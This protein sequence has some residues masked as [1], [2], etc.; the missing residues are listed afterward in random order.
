MRISVGKSRKDMDWRVKEL[1]WD[2]LM[3]Q[4]ET[5]VRTKETIN[6]YKG[7]SKG[8]KA[9]IKDVGGFVGGVISGGRRKNG[10]VTSRSLVTLDADTA[11][12]RLW[13]N[14][15]FSYDWTMA[16]YTTHSHQPAKPRLRLLFELDR[17]VSAEEYVPI[18]R[19]LAEMIGI[20]QFDPTTYEPT[21]L[22]YWP[23]VCADG[24][25]LFE[26][27]EG[28]P[29]CA[30]DILAE[31]ED[32]RDT[33]QWPM[34]AE[35]NRI[36]ERIAKNQGEP[37]E[38]AG[39]VGAFCRT[40]NAQEA[41]DTFLSDVYVPA[42]GDRYT[43]VPGSTFAGVV[44]YNDG[45]FSYSHHATDPAGGYLCN[46]FDLVRLHK[47]KDLD[48][49]AE[50]GTPVNKL[51]SYQK[52]LELASEDVEVKKLILA[53]KKKEL[54]EDFKPVD[55]DWAAL[56]TFTK[57]GEVEPTRKNIITILRYDDAY[58]DCFAYNE[59]S[60][61]DVIRKPLDWKTDI[62][63]TNGTAITDTDVRLLRNRLEASYGISGKDMIDDALAEV[64]HGNRFH[65]VRSYLQGLHW[66][67]VRRM[68]EL[69]IDYMGAEDCAYSRIVT[70]RWLISAVARIMRPGCKADA[71]LVL[72][73]AQG[74]GK[75]Y[76]TRR[77][78]KH[79]SSDT[80]MTVTGKDAYD[81]LHGSWIIEVSELAATRKADV[82]SVKS[83][84]SKQ[85]DTYRAAYAK[86]A[87]NFP[88][89]CVFLGTTNEQE[90]LIDTTGN[91]RFWPLDLTGAPANSVFDL[92][93]EYVDLV[94][95]EAYKAYLD[96]EPWWLT[97][98]ETK[99]LLTAQESHLDLDPVIGQ[100]AEYL[101][102]DLPENWKDLT[103]EQ[104]RDF[105]QGY[106]MPTEVPL[107]FKRQRICIPELV[108]EMSKT[109]PDDLKVPRKD[110]Y[111]FRDALN[112]V[113][114][115]RRNPKRQKPNGWGDQVCWDRKV[116]G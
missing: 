34:A 14:L 45:A 96:G 112:Q 109:P 72:V 32:W 5:P 21:R 113:P 88:R 25:Y 38:K 30:D 111:R 26:H 11:M 23:S 71:M 41:M 82:E 16:M 106:A 100:I 91:R 89:Q 116:D 48:A 90:F 35:E 68:S 99:F 53:E 15:S 86:R 70:K 7:M 50:P 56:L 115:W 75:S 98:Q 29:V 27:Q 39:L 64:T 69:F 93:D 108:Y 20:E 97:P 83:F 37:T 8:K 6:E 81:Q 59:F 42:S 51:P 40:Y 12:P 62:D 55:T 110:M 17:E 61:R 2:E 24:E 31:Y 10:A 47:F 13:D 18:A 77:L 3:E 95:A 43:Y 87:E 114:G 49:E 66:D 36:Y 4:L 19:K 22:M 67:G 60:C 76:I 85:V 79:W 92:T 1:S 44:L 102:R 52:M 28:S 54:A 74:L 46:A 104:R 80:F 107:T 94:W 73:G 105:I 9:E 58:K 63:S 84:I 33:I 57:K 65:P 103:M 101:D 78:G